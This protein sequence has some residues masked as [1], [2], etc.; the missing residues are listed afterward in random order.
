MCICAFICEMSVDLSLDPALLPEQSNVVFYKGY[1][2][3]QISFKGYI[4]YFT[5]SKAFLSFLICSILYYTV[6]F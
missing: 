3:F 5:E 2:N 1:F 4:G 6:N